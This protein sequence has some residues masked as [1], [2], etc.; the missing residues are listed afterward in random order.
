MQTIFITGAT[1]G[2]GKLAAIELAAK[3]KEATM[4]VHGRNKAKLDEVIAAIK[5]DSGNEHIEGYVADFSSLAEVKQLADDVLLKHS[6]INI[7]INNAGAGFAAPRYGKDGMETRF[8]VNYLAPFLLTN[9]LLPAIKKAA[10]SRIV[11]VSSA[12]QSAINFDDVM[13][14]KNFDGVTAYTQSKLAL[15]MFTFDL[16]EQ[17]KDDNVTVNALHPGTYLDTNMVNDAGIKPL[18]T[19]QSGADAEVYLATSEDLK[20]ITGKYFNIKKE[21][22]VHTQAYD[23]EAREKLRAITL[24]LTDLI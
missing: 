6:F 11:N 16:A 12:G 3:D 1:D 18:G 15:I 10:P 14:T 22:K 20:N 17:L 4:I 13:L 5:H 7:L 24:K 19:A 8:T 9:L 2:I 21:A 23:L